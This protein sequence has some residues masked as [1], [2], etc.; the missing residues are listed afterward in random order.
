MLLLSEGLLVV[1]SVSS[2][3]GS[4]QFLL[5]ALHEFLLSTPALAVVVVVVAIKSSIHLLL[6]RPHFKLVIEKL[7]KLIFI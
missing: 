4:V 2:G 6:S 5:L 1:G 7:R 3:V